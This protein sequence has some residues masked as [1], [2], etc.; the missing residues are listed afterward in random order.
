MTSDAGLENACEMWSPPGV[1]ARVP[2]TGPVSP[3]NEGPFLGVT[4]KL[5]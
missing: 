3:H 4:L 1:T 2:L 5:A